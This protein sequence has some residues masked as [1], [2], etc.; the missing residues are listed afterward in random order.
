MKDDIRTEIEAAYESGLAQQLFEVDGYR[1][2]IVR[3][4][5]EPHVIDTSALDERLRWAKG[6]AVL[7]DEGSFIAYL[8]RFWRDDESVVFVGT[9]SKLNA[10]FDYHLSQ[11]AIAPGMVQGGRSDFRASFAP[12]FT[13]AWSAWRAASGKS[14]DQIELLEF[15]EERIGEIASPDGAELREIIQFF[16]VHNELGFVSGKNLTNGT[17]NFQWAEEATATAGSAGELTVP[18]EFRVALQPF[19]DLP[20][21]RKMFTAQLRWRIQ[22]PKVTFSFHLRNEELDDYVEA[23]NEERRLRISAALGPDPV[24]FFGAPS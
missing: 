19:R 16:K 8:R 2:A 3:D 14:L 21:D 23:L 12:R 20:D 1:V 13:P 9:D 5:Y 11:V 24:V 18:T 22:R 10:I 4:G 15:I 7:A 6:N 17:V